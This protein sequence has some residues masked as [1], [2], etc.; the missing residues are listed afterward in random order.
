MQWLC[1]G[2]RN[3][4]AFMVMVM[5]RQLTVLQQLLCASATLIAGCRS[6]CW[7]HVHAAYSAD[8]LGADAQRV[9]VHNACRTL[10][11]EIGAAAS[12]AAAAAVG[13][14]PLSSSR[15]GKYSC[16][17]SAGSAAAIAAAAA[18][19]TVLLGMDHGFP[20]PVTAAVERGGVW[21]D[22]LLVLGA[23]F[24]TLLMLRKPSTYLQFEEMNGEYVCEANQM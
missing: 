4:F 13:W 15:P 23:C 3:G 19:A 5:V 11:H 7:A 9:T 17:G 1:R 24:N 14:L 2:Q 21:S 8:F 22:L 12:A 10:Q 20:N 16:T 18:A 6:G